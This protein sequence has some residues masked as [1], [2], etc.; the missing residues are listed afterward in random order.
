V[1]SGREI[2]TAAVTVDAGG[3]QVVAGLRDL[4]V[5]KSTGSQFTGFLTD[6][7]TTLPETLDRV[8]ATSLDIAWRYDGSTGIDWDATYDDVLALLVSRF[9]TLHSLALQQTLWHMGTAVLE[10]H[11]RVVEIR[12]RAPNRHH[13]EFDLARFGLEQRGEVFH[14]PDRPYGLIEAV[15][16]RDDAPPPGDAWRT[17]AGRQ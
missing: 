9:A 7:Y 13:I 16:A 11:P 12:L 10:A 1:R 4:V 3:E 6:E 2:R 8:L 15:I 14:A 17:S 5:L